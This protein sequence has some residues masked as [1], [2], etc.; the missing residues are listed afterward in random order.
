MR[1]MPLNH[2][3]TLGRSGLRVSPF[4]LV[5][6][7]FGQEWNWGSDVETSQRIIDRYIERGGNFLDT[8]N[9]YTK[10]HSEV[11]IGDHI[12]RNPHKRDR[13]VIATKFCSNLYPGDA[14]GGGANRKS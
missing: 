14:N 11:I 3:I 5:T 9:A 4:C 10:G 6:M 13:V 2:T 12:G 1:H 7:T 8:A